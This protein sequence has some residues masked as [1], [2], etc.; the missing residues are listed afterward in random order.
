MRSKTVILSIIFLLAFAAAANSQT[1]ELAMSD[2]QDFFAGK[3]KIDGKDSYEH[4][5][6][7]AEILTGRGYKIIDGAEKLSENLEIKIV[8]G[9]ICYLATVPDQN[10]G[11]TVR[12]ELTRF[13]KNEMI[14]E[15]PAHDFPKKLIYQKDSPTEMF[16]QVL[17]TG[18]KGFSF[19]MT[20]A[21]TE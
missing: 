12:F 18:D 1:E 10:E 9:K 3:W 7:S 11:K 5:E 2:V 14:F 21:K 17:G 20:K 16:V 13:S 6:I 8:D 19:R 15:N 4:W